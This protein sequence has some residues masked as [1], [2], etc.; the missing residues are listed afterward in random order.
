MAP[1]LMI[2]TC[3]AALG[4]AAS[5]IFGRDQGLVLIAG[6]KSCSSSIIP[7]IFIRSQH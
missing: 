1:A 5:F 2:N 6:P 7:W 4:K 3:K